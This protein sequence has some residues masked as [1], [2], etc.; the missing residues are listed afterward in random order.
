MAAL[1]YTVQIFVSGPGPLD[2]VS[3]IPPGTQKKNDP[4]TGILQ[5][6]LPP[7]A[8]LGK[9]DPGELVSPT[10]QKT[11]MA[12]TSLSVVSG[13]PHSP[14]SFV[15]IET[16]P[17][18]GAPVKVRQLL[19]LALPDPAGVFE[20][21]GLVYQPGQKMVIDTIADGATGPH[22]I[23]ATIVVLNSECGVDLGALVSLIPGGGGGGV[24]TNG[25][26]VGV[27]AD[28][29]KILNGTI[30]EFRRLSG[31]GGISVVQNGD[32]IEISGGGSGLPWQ[33]NPAGAEPFSLDVTANLSETVAYDGTS[34]N[35]PFTIE[36]PPT[37]NNNDI[38]QVKEVRGGFGFGVTLSGNGSPIENYFGIPVASFGL[39]VPSASLTY[40]YYA[41]DGVWRLV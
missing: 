26:N 11:N 39:V 10:Y 29:F 9:F 2:G 17:G 41:I 19:D 24:V 32:T 4:I 20:Q 36:A 21:V 31:L 5:V 16:L 3:P 23:Q 6:R 33:V 14:G 18:I 27:G 22:L 38:F 1:T 34:P 35:G 13:A 40:Q 25:A 12:V 30:L 15:G 28:V 8:P 37:P 7:G